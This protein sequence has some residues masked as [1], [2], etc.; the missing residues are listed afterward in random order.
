MSQQNARYLPEQDQP[1]LAG[2]NA[3]GKHHLPVT[4][5]P[6]CGHLEGVLSA[7]LS[8]VQSKRSAAMAPP[9]L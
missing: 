2:W 6:F 3:Y 5:L 4:Y 7:F 9:N 8:P 1:L